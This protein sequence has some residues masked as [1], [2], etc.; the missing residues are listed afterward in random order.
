MNS[1]SANAIEMNWELKIDI[2]TTEEGR[3]CVMVSTIELRVLQLNSNCK[4]LE[5]TKN[6]TLFHTY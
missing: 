6:S 2:A 4:K 1:L 5:V 3:M